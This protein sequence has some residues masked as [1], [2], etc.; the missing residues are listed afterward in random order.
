MTTLHNDTHEEITSDPKPNYTADV[1]V[2]DLS[3]VK[4]DANNYDAVWG[5]LSE[6]GPNYRNLGWVRAF[7]LLVKSQIGLGV[8]GMVGQHAAY[9]R[10]RVADKV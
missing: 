8:L 1:E 3:D 4:P 2:Q 9:W 10:E 5:Q 6:R 7:V